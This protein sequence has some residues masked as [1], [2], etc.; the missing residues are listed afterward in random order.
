MGDFQNQ[1]RDSNAENESNH[2]KQRTSEQRVLEQVGIG[3]ERVF[4]R[5]TTPNQTN[6]K[7]NRQHVRHGRDKLR[8]LH[9]VPIL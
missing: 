6:I 4:L 7:E 1:Q 3:L 9:F 8:I 2:E 5:I